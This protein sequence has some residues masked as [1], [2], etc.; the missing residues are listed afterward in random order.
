MAGVH[1]SEELMAQIAMR[2]VWWGELMARI[3]MRVA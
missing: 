1:S 2:G 3:E